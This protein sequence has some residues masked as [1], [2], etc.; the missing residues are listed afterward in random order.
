MCPNSC[1]AYTGP[2]STLE[3][4][5]YCAEPRYTQPS[6]SRKRTAR[7]RFSTIPLGPQLQAMY[8]SPES[9]DR[10]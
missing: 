1:I 10:M 7:R 9:A 2:F 4:C 8:R 3:E 6:T 5:P